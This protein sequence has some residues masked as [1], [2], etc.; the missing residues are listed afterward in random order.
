MYKYYYILRRFFLSKKMT[1][2][3]VLNLSILL[4]III[5][6]FIIPLTL[7]ISN[8]FKNNIEDKIIKFDGYARIFNDNLTAEQR[9]YLLTN[10][11]L[12]LLQFNEQESIVKANNIPEG[13]TYLKVDNIN[14]LDSF[15][16]NKSYKTVNGIY[17]GSQLSEKLFSNINS[18][19]ENI[20][21]INNSNIH[22]RNVVGIFNTNIPLYDKHIIIE[23]DSSIINQGYIISKNDYSTINKET[24]INM[25]TYKDRY[26][27]FIKWLDTYN[28]PIN[29]LLLF[30]I[31][32]ALINNSFCFK[33]D[34]IN[35]CKDINIIKILGFSKRSIVKLFWQKYLILNLSGIIIGS[36]LCFILLIIEKKY[37][38]IELPKDIYFTSKIP[39]L[40]NAKYFFI[41]PVILSIDILC[42]RLIIKKYIHE[43]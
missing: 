11:D 15:L 40:M 25:Y 41:V 9:E 42:K 3:S 34:L 22:E 20:F 8:G 30:I 43:Y 6:A 1:L 38:F 16:I 19:D 4:S 32:I 35:R 36:L 18:L 2:K 7:S 39:I 10:H 17:I 29:L 24:K 27:D 28:V 13:V 23:V 26:Y 5:C 14:F 21:I 37:S 31:L 33:I 12:L